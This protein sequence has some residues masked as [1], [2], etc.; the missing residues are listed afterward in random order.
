VIDIGF[1]GTRQGCTAAQLRTLGA[2]FQRMAAGGSPDGS[3][4]PFNH[5]TIR[6]HHGDCEGADAEFHT[7]VLAFGGDVVLHPPLVR[8]LRAE[9]RHAVEERPPKK[10]L[11]RDHDIADESVWV[12]ACPK[13]MEEPKQKRGGG[14]WAT[15]RY[16]AGELGKKP[17]GGARKVIVILPDGS[18]VRRS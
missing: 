12:I 1:T 8:D 4:E 6:G 14:T 15:V 17:P 11:A 3:V 10:F 13:E 16:S 5:R 7:L 2:I 9:C 18:E